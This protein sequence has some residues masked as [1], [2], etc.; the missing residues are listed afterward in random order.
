MDNFNFTSNPS[1]TVGIELEL[2]LVD[3]ETGA[4]SNSIAA[5]LGR[6][7]AKFESH[8][9]PELMQSYVEINTRV[10]DTIKDAEDDLIQKLACLQH[11]TDDLGL[12]LYWSATHPFSSWQDQKVT[13]VARYEGLVDLLQDMARQLVCFGLHVHVG[14][15]S[16]D[17]AVAICD[18][19][20]RHLPALLALSC[21]S[22]WWENR[23]SGLQSHRSKIMEGLAT[24]GL[25][26]VMRNWSEYVWLVTH[27]IETGFINSIREIWWDVRP[28]HNFGTVEVR[29][30]DMPGSL[31]DSLALAAL[32]QCLVT[33]LSHEIDRGTYQHN[34][35]PM[36]VRQ[37]KWRASR[38]G[39]DAE[40]IDPAT[41]E[42]QRVRDLV[43]QLVGQLRSTAKE[44]NCDAYLDR[45][46][47]IAE[48]KSW[49]DR[50]L[51]VLRE[52]G[53]PSDVV[54]HFVSVSRAA[55]LGHTKQEC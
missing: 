55:T 27:L 3:A 30:C 35:H 18:R 4:L 11:I 5:V 39:L 16:G 44:L 21:N 52:S 41:C 10:C 17:K 42:P 26:P 20:M 28:H 7:P 9:K 43:P 47:K 8:I 50:Q 15:D 49:A 48:G 25:P 34:F 36:M 53:S 24:A 19:M 1:P 45:V 46:L 2:A 29:I 22:P 38:F 32:I 54:R 14:V 23:V 6:V 13:P 40:L 33:S 37:N 12:G 51:E 31:E